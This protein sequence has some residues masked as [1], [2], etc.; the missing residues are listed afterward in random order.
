MSAHTDAVKI[1]MGV[2]EVARMESTRHPK[3]NGTA[4]GL[5]LT[6]ADEELQ[7]AD[8][9]TREE[10]LHLRDYINEHLDPKESPNA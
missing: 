3:L 4:I 8:F 9:L 5:R 7:G 6:G 2:W 1:S 10:A